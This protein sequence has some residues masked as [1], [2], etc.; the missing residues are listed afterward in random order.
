MFLV[1]PAIAG[2]GPTDGCREFST[3]DEPGWL[4]MVAMLGGLGTFAVV[5]ETA[6]AQ[7]ARCAVRPKG[8]SPRRLRPVT[9]GLL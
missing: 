4:D 9:A 6:A 2:P 3:P 8:E 7:P 1:T 5:A